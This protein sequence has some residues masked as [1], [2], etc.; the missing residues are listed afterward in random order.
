MLKHFLI[1]WLLLLIAPQAW[2]ASFGEASLESFLAQPLKLEIP[3]VLSKSEMGS[4]VTVELASPQE[5]KFLEQS[6]PNAYPWIKVTVD[7][8][9]AETWRVHVS[10]TRAIDESYL[11][12]ILKVQRGRGNYFKK[13]SVFLD[14]VAS[15]RQENSVA[16]AQVIESEASTPASF[17]RLKASQFQGNQVSATGGWARRSSYGPIQSGDSLSEIAYRL[18]KDKRWSNHQIMLT[19]FDTNPAAFANNNIN[20]LKKGA[21]LQVPNDEEVE[22]FVTSP[23]YDA[24]QSSTT[25]AKKVKPKLKSIAKPQAVADRQGS[26]R[27]RTKVSLGLAES[28]D[29]PIRDSIIMEK[30]DKL[31]PLYQQAMESN[32][33]IDSIGSKVDDLAVEVRALNA[34]VEALSKMTTTTFNANSIASNTES[35]Y[36]WYWFFILIIVNVILALFYLYRKQMKKWQDKLSQSHYQPHGAFAG[37]NIDDIENSKPDIVLS[38][39]FEKE[40][41]DEPVVRQADEPSMEA[42][43]AHTVHVDEDT[44]EVSDSID[45]ASAFEEAVFKKNWDDAEKWYA[46]MFKNVK[47]QPRIQ[48]LYIQMLYETERVVERNN[49]LLKLYE[50]YSLSQWN[51]FCSLLDVHIWQKL[52]DERIISFMG[53]VSEPDIEKSNLKAAELNEMLGGDNFDLADTQIAM[54][55]ASVANAKSADDSLDKTVIMKSVEMKNWRKTLRKRALEE[56]AYTPPELIDGIDNMEWDKVD[57]SDV[58]ALEVDDSAFDDTE[59]GGLDADF[60]FSSASEAKP[61]PSDDW[62]YTEVE[63]PAFDET[64]VG[65]LDVDFDISGVTE[66]KPEVSDEWDYTEVDIQF[67]GELE[68]DVDSEANQEAKSNN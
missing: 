51:R 28:L 46:E 21:F 6:M 30:L 40:I 54:N 2:A 7:K 4:Q 29:A 45:L 3:V 25:V 59:V 64:M 27:F 12:V 67:T 11:V 16:T 50:A 37:D 8:Q 23:R 44:G 26:S 39:S 55:D 42:S 58:S 35:G 41:L 53:I 22:S 56:E 14:P 19:L 36:G 34:K 31:E 17:P 18:R 61:E 48:A 15:P 24:L 32:L 52:Q 5:Y 43:G 60:D 62:D 63:E 65:A 49:T 9:N 38:P 68:T 20:L 57:D 47:K 1:F 13:I 66:A 33:R 10:S